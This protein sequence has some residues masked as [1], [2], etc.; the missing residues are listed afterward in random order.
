MYGFDTGTGLPELCG[1]HRDHPDKWVPADYPMDLG[2]LQKRLSLRTQLI[3]GNVRETVPEFSSNVLSS[4]I[5]FAAI[6]LDLYSSSKHVLSLFCGSNR[7][8]LRRTYLYFD[9]VADPKATFFHK[10]AGE[11][12]AI[13]EFNDSSSEVK[14]DIW[15][16]LRAGRIFP[17]SPWIEKMYIAH[18]LA[19]IDLARTKRPQLQDFGLDS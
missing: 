13:D 11:L 9:D 8:M 14:I 7:K 16:G 19:A 2:A 5:G 18:D 3:I 12:L 10:F 4:P 6:D 1:D 17:E 15:R